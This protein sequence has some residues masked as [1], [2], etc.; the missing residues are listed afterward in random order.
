MTLTKQI[1]QEK[2]KLRQEADVNGEIKRK[3]DCS[4]REHWKGREVFEHCKYQSFN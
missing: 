4:L 2:K 1:R 3:Y